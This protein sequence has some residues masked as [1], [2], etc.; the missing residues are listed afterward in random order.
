MVIG[1]LMGFL[2]IIVVDVGSLLMDVMASRHSVRGWTVIPGWVSPRDLDRP[3]LRVD[4]V[5]L[6][7]APLDSSCGTMLDLCNP[8]LHVRAGY[9]SREKKR[10]PA[11]CD[12]VIYRDNRAGPTGECN[13]E[14]P[15]VSST[16]LYEACMD[17]TESDH[18]PVR[19]KFHCT[20]AHV[21]RSVRTHEFGE[22]MLS[23]KK[24]KAIANELHFVLETVVS[25]NS[26]ILQ[27][28]D[29]SVI[30]ITNKCDKDKAVYKVICD[31]QSTAKDE[32]DI[33]EYHP[34]GAF[35]FPHWLEVICN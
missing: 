1:V 35:G 22:V 9:D 15:I 8:N 19:C 28:Q 12:R 7:R 29:T 26:I 31:G 3:F 6:P 16:L 21:D 33:A 27:S 10:I 11:W 25:T 14:C 20:I 34:R 2:L 4:N 32:E 23:N 24:I 18:K 5:W 13:L 17:V 30:R